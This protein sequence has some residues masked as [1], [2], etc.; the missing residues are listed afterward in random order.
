MPLYQVTI[1]PYTKRLKIARLDGHDIP[2]HVFIKYLF[3]STEYLFSST[4]Y[5]L[6]PH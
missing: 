2:L 6:M 4:K 5:L 3:D 1:I